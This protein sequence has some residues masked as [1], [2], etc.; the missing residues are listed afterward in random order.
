MKKIL[1]CAVVALLL[2]TLAAEAPATQ[3]G[4]DRGQVNLDWFLRRNQRRY[5][6]ATTPQSAF[7][8]SGYPA[9]GTGYP[10][11]SGF[12][13]T[14]PG[15]YG[16]R[17]SY[18]VTGSRY[19]R[20]YSGVCR[21][22]SYGCFG[23]YS[24]ATHWGGYPVRGLYGGGYPGAAQHWSAYPA[25]GWTWNEY[26]GAGQSSSSY[27]YLRQE[28]SGFQG[29]HWNPTGVGWPPASTSTTAVP[30][31]QPATTETQTRPGRSDAA[32]LQKRAKKWDER[33]RQAEANNTPGADQIRLIATQYQLEAAAA[34]LREA[35]QGLRDAAKGHDAATRAG[36]EAAAG[37][38][39]ASAQSFDAALRA[40]QSGGG[41]GG[42]PV[43]QHPG[44]P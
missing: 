30:P 25:G 5:G 41:G 22:T 44:G 34:T 36:L 29:W 32:R 27:P 2:A 8:G 21:A 31:E 9:S 26:A 15:V 28:S 18:P 43:P 13:Y 10:R 14:T 16:N 4:S 6:S 19:Y 24:P 1:K 38:M 39:E 37:A 17:P 33:A 23:S 20:Y 11:G 3:K 12:N 42:L 35:A 40:V 7:W